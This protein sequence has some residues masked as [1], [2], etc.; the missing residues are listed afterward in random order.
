MATKAVDA[1]HTHP[2]KSFLFPSL[3]LACFLTWLIMGF[4]PHIGFP[5][6]HVNT[7]VAGRAQFSWV[8]GMVAMIASMAA[9]AS[10][11]KSRTKPTPARLSVNTFTHEIAR[12]ARIQSVC[13]AC[14]MSIGTVSFILS[15]EHNIAILLGGIACGLGIPFMMLA[16]FGGAVRHTPS[17]SLWIAC[18]STLITGVLAFGCACLNPISA[19]FIYMCLPIMSCVFTWIS[20]K[21]CALFTTTAQD[22]CVECPQSTSLF[23]AW[24]LMILFSLLVVFLSAS[25]IGSPSVLGAPHIPAY[26]L[27]STLIPVFCIIG[28]THALTRGA[29]KRAIMALAIVSVVATLISATTMHATLLSACALIA[30][31]CVCTAFMMHITNIRDTDKFDTPAFNTQCASYC[32]WII[33]AIIAGCLGG[34]FLRMKSNASLTSMM[35]IISGIVY[36]LTM[37]AML[38]AT[39][40]KLSQTVIHTT[41]DTPYDIA[42]GRT[43]ILSRT[44]TDISPREADV[45]TYMLL[46]CKEATIAEKLSISPSTVRRH[47]EHIYTK[48]GVTTPEEFDEIVSKVQVK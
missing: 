10:F 29:H 11:G 41:F 44:Y 40:K 36:M 21:E 38:F 37:V 23:D 6:P 7:P 5:F 46:S 25:T 42:R 24:G 48:M 32:T 22:I 39:N 33:F 31:I 8:L 26:T 43:E 19:G 4:I 9:I 20:I 18:L 27:L 2:F 3:A 1:A 17:S 16:W 35:L 15:S 47:I 28:L 13:A 34:D 30:F 14:L 12:N 45:L